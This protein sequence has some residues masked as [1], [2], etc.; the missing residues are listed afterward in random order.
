MSQPH[1]YWI[2]RALAL[3]VIAVAAGRIAYG[4]VGG[5]AL[6]VTVTIT[7]VVTSLVLYFLARVDQK[8]QKAFTQQTGSF[9]YPASMKG[10]SII[11]LGSGD[12]SQ[13]S[14]DKLFTGK[15]L[16]TQDTLTWKPKQADSGS[17]VSLSWSEIKTYRFERAS[18]ALLPATHFYITTQWGKMGYVTVTNSKGLPQLVETYCSRSP[19]N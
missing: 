10:E 6:A 13:I 5:A 16:I 17:L 1:R 15:L 19:T 2:K 14:A 3:A 12:I 9:E 8:S 11:Q 7:V 4:H 18:L